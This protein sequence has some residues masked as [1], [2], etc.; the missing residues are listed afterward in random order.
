VS[1][2]EF[3]FFAIVVRMNKSIYYL[4]VITLLFLFPFFV[5]AQELPHPAS[6]KGNIVGTDNEPIP[7]VNI[8]VKKPLRGTSSNVDGNFTFVFP[9]N[10][11]EQY[12]YISAIGFKSDSIWL[13]KQQTSLNFQM[14]PDIFTMDEVLITPEKYTL[15]LREI[16]KKAFQRIPENYP[17]KPVCYDVFYRETNKTLNGKYVAVAEAMLDIFKNSYNKPKDKGQVRID[18]SRKSIIPQYDSIVFMHFYGGAYAFIAKDHVLIR[19]REIDP[20]YYNNFTYTLREITRYEGRDVYVIEFV[21]KMKD[22]ISGRLYIE[23]NG[24]AY[25]KIDIATTQTVPDDGFDRTH[26]NESVQ[27]FQHEGKWHLQQIK[28]TD[29]KNIH[30][31]GL[32]FDCSI[33]HLTVEITTDSV[34]SIPHKQRIS[35]YDPFYETAENY[36]PNYWEGYNILQQDSTLNSILESLH[37]SEDIKQIMTSGYAADEVDSLLAEVRNNQNK[38]LILVTRDTET[39]KKK[40]QLYLKHF[41][42]KIYGGI[43]MHYQPVSSIAGDYQLQ[44]PADGSMLSLNPNR[45]TQNVEY[46]L[47][48]LLGLHLTNNWNIYWTGLN[49]VLFKSDIS[50]LNNQIGT[51]YRINLKKRGEPLYIGVTAAFGWGRYYADFGK[52]TNTQGAFTADGKTINA[53][54]LGIQGGVKQT[55][56]SPGISFSGKINKI[57]EVE[58]YARYNLPLTQRSVAVI[59]EKDGFFLSR[60]KAVIDG[61]DISVNGTSS[62]YVNVTP[63]Q[64]GIILKFN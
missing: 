17:T 29:Y 1:A 26:I 37:K 30:A 6:V 57:F 9:P 41:P 55:T 52:I 12:L 36:N 43:G 31:T 49:N 34:Q 18:K 32:T 46:A 8:Y 24:F 33:E 39:N 58:L 62:K 63:F 19:S 47:D 11:R 56:F 13:T 10:Y 60:K 23:A 64:A 61:D 3:L 59:K 25:I 2:K 50:I 5:N 38:Q 42:Q 4:T 16:L 7:A 48:I 28:Y 35:Y 21:S 53:D 45:K 14:K 15:G 20:D 22:D 44:H 27:Y 51:E 40:R 54:Q